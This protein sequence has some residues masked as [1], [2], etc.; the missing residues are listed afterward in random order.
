M[1]PIPTPDHAEVHLVCLH[2]LQSVTMLSCAFQEPPVF[3][4]LQCSAASCAARNSFSAL[5]CKSL[6]HGE[7]EMP[8]D[9]FH[10]KSDIWSLIRMTSCNFSWREIW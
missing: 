2:I 5:S 3:A 9:L 1:D 4:M 8:K 7:A 6:R 10:T